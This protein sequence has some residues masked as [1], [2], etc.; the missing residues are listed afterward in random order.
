MLSYSLLKNRV[1]CFK[2]TAVYG[3]QFIP[4]TSVIV[5]TITAVNIQVRSSLVHWLSKFSVNKFKIFIIDFCYFKILLI[6]VLSE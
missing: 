5:L 3:E 2:I 1:L 4:F 6:L